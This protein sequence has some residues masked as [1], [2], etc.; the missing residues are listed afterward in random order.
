MSRAVCRRRRRRGTPGPARARRLSGLLLTLVF[1]LAAPPVRAQLG[2][3]TA[4]SD[5]TPVDITSESLE[6]ESQRDVYVARGN[7]V[8]R[9]GDRRLEADWVAFN[10]RTREGLASGNVRLY[11]GPDTLHADFLQF[12]VDTLRGVV[13]E[14]FL[15]AKATGFKLEGKQIRKTDEQAYY[16]EKGRFTTC[17]C[18]DGGRDP[19]AIRADVATVEV[20]EWAVARNSTL[21]VLGIPVFWMPWMAYPLEN[22][23]QS[24]FLMPEFGQSNRSGFEIGTPFFWAAHDRVNVILTPAYFGKRGLA[25]KIQVEYVNGELSRGDLQL[26]IVP[27]DAEVDPTDPSTPFDTFRWALRFDA[28]QELPWSSRLLVDLKLISDNEYVSDFRDWREFDNDRFLE[29]IAFVSRPFG[30]A[31][32]YGAVAAV[33]WADDLQSPEP[34]DRDRFL[35]QRLPDVT[36]SQ[37]ASRPAWFDRIVTSFDARYT[38]FWNQDRPQEAFPGVPLVGDSIFADTGI[39]ALPDGDELNED[40][41]TV[42]LAGREVARNGRVVTAASIVAGNPEADTSGF[43]ARFDPDQSLDNAPTGPE[44]DGEFQEG[45][46]LADRGHRF[47]LNPRVALPL[48]FGPVELYPELGYHGTFYQTLAQGVEQ[49]SLGTARVDVRTRL[50]REF[51]MPLLGEDAIHVVEPQLSY[52]NVTKFNQSDLPLFV[53]RPLVEQ[54]R[55]RMLALENVLRDPAD[56]IRR[57]NGIVVGVANRLYTRQQRSSRDAPDAPYVEHRLLADV[58]AAVEYQISGDDLGQFVTSGTL[59]PLPTLDVRFNLALE[60]EQLAFAEAFL[61]FGWSS[62]RG[63]DLRIGYRFVQDIP[64]FFEDFAFD[65]ERFEDFRTGFGRINQV[66][67]SARWAITANWAVTYDLGYTIEEGLILGNRAGVEY[68]SRC[69]CWA[70]RVTLEEDRAR[71]VEFGFEYRII[72]LGDDRVRPF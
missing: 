14:G 19:W 18:P 42:D 36:F 3:A 4:S 13:F 64:R 69:G 70:A 23:R 8:I 72:G 20:D 9:Q 12:D 46:P 52:V 50:Q 38:Y 68:I 58:S 59:H 60:L 24:G 56:R 7:V 37:M 61:D 44:G 29:S 28:D 54:Q 55:V 30:G 10:D 39:D 67:L 49:R 35:L 26:R 6:Y 40:G 71:G 17:D 57:F 47:V 16:F 51:R 32:P 5:G 33:W 65:E 22:D 41:E 63:H 45:E 53:P 21:E 15:E 31:S 27:D 48:R 62:P 66:R 2:G 1:A 34:V 43:G 25:P 11:D